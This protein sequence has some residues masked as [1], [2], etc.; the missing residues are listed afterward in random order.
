VQNADSI[1]PPRSSIRLIPW[2]VLSLSCLAPSLV[3]A[4]T[5]TLL[6]RAF[7]RWADAGQGDLAFTQETRVFLSNGN[8]KE[9]RV[10]RYDPS[11]PDSSRWRLLEI[12]GQPATD[13]QS[14]KW[15]ARKNGRPRRKVDKSPSQLLDL[16]HAVL[17]RD[18]EQRAR[19]RIPFRPEAERLLDINQI[20]LVVTVDKQSDNIVGIGA[21][22][23]QPIHALL[24]LVRIT[25]LDVN[26]HISEVEE[27]NSEE[28]ENVDPGSTARLT[29]S[30]LG[31]SMEYNWSEFKRVT[32]FA[33]SEPGR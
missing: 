28:Y 29:I 6:S 11:Q 19:Y 17:L 9:E 10:E 7:Q 14:L 2:L 18:F 23:R 24:G 22:L 33:S 4:E 26:L 1:Q 21:A 5:P 12:G 31:N 3:D 27:G 20:D 32:P 15:E 25:E 8:V 16:D 13:Q 30:K